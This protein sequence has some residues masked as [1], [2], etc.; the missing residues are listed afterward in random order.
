MTRDDAGPAEPGGATETLTDERTALA[1]PW[2]V[3]VHDDPITLMSYVVMV[4]RKVFGYAEPRARELM[5]EVHVKGRSIVWTGAREQAEMYA[6][7]L[8]GH[9]LLASIERDAS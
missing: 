5:M 4:F 9:Q 2:K 8:H 3:I 1:R 7:K 6:Q